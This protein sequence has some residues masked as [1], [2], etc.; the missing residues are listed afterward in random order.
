MEEFD[1]VGSGEADYGAGFEEGGERAGG[2]EVRIVVERTVE[3]EKGF[4]WVDGTL[5]ALHF[6]M[7]F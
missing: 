2:L 3:E 1:G 7:S 6:P 4:E 5:E